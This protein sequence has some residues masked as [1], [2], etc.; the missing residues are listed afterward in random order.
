MLHHLSETVSLAK[1]G[2]QTHIFQMIFEI[3]P[4]QAILLTLTLIHASLFCLCCDS[5][6]FDL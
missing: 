6:F 1:L 5:L 3:S 4:L 2:H